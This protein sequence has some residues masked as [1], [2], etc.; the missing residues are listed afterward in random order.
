MI[1]AT[2]PEVELEG[3]VVLWLEGWIL[4]IR[5]RT[6]AST[7]IPNIVRNLFVTTK[8]GIYLLL[9]QRTYYGVDPKETRR[10]PEGDPK[11]T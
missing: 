1:L 7:V 11:E 4:D 2:H 6:N 10:R 5:R 8:K 9:I 3:G